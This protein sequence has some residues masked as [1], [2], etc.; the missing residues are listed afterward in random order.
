[1]FNVA[2]SQHLRETTAVWMMILLV[3]SLLGNIIL[4]IAMVIVCKRK[5][6]KEDI[7]R[8]RVDPGE[9]G[10]PQNLDYE[11]PQQSAV[12]QHAYQ[13]LKGTGIDN[14]QEGVYDDIAD[15][16]KLE[17][18]NISSQV[19]KKLF[20]LNVRRHVETPDCVNDTRD[21]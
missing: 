7:T 19:R 2:E 9:A 1:M 12:R 3:I 4:A 11:L 16:E 13:G 21:L 20:P 5:Q 15:P 10:D 18:V 14:I 8:V 17:Y 6:K